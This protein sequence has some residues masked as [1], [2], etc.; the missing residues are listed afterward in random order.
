MTIIFAGCVILTAGLLAY[1]FTLP[2]EVETVEERTRVAYLRERKEQVYENLRDLNFEYKA[3]KLPEADYL[4]MRL[5]MEEEAAAI[6]AEMENLE[7]PV[8]GKFGFAAKQ[9]PKGARV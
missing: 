6:L 5:A 4:T 1:M 7:R 3:G 2:P 8:N 9:S